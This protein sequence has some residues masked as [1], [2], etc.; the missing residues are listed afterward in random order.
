MPA[1]DAARLNIIQEGERVLRIC[2]ACR[3]CEGFCAVFPAMERRRSFAEAD[4]N[5]LANLCHNCGECYYACQYAPPHEFA[6]NVPKLL[7]EIRVRSYEKY[8]WPKF[9]GLAFRANGTIA[10]V[11]L[12]LCAWLAVLIVEGSLLSRNFELRFYDIV[13]HGAMVRLYGSVSVVILVVFAIG[14]SRFWRDAGGPVTPAALARGLKDALTLHYLDGGGGGCAYP[15]EKQS[16]ARRW[17]HHL[18]FYGFGLCFAS[19]VTAAFYHYA[20]GWIAPYDYLSIP[21]ILGSAGGIAIV[22]G[23]LGLFALKAIRDPQ[24][25]DRKQ[26]GMD[27]SFLLLLLLSSV[28]GLLLLAL[29]ESR[30][31][32]ELL[33]LH[34]G[35]VLALFLTLPYGKFVHGIYRSAA[36]VKY[37][38]ERHSGIHR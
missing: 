18:A 11:L 12:V 9:A 19:T 24:T 10:A 14:L 37:A 20:L 5:Y 35:I 30:R 13:S 25:Q 6:V 22:A 7:A 34:L 21:V 16:Q 17:F 15:A 3:Y 28:S 29:R 2:N 38:L 8:C 4:L 36:L 26:T 27:V 33:G 32:P 23:T 31:M 1:S